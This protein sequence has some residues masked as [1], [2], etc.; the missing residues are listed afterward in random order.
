MYNYAAL[1]TDVNEIIG[2]IASAFPAKEGIEVR[3]ELYNDLNFNNMIRADEASIDERTGTGKLLEILLHTTEGNEYKQFDYINKS[4]GDVTK[5]K[6]FYTI[7]ASINYINR[8]NT[9]YQYASNNANVFN[10]SSQVKINNLSRMNEVFEI[11]KTHKQDFMY[12]YKSGSNTIKNTY[13]ALVFIL[14]DL[15][16][17]NMIDVTNFMEH[18]VQSELR[19]E[20]KVPF[21]VQWSMSRNGRYMRSVDR[22][23]KVFHDGSWNK[24]VMVIRNQNKKYVMEEAASIGLLIAIIGAIPLIAVTILYLIRFFIAFYFETAVD[25]K[26]K[27]GALADYISE[28]AKSE[29]NPAAL[30]KQT[31]A[32][33]ILRNTANFLS[34]KI[35]K[36]DAVGMAKVVEADRELKT[37][38]YIS[39]REYN[40]LTNSGINTAEI[41]FE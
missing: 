11:L 5:L 7:N 31:K 41:T 4:K 30:Y 28:V 35:L 34:T 32:V 6:D 17:M 9:D 3:K 19:D 40:N 36:E 10:I 37:T 18:S 14:V 21:R 39:D 16:C 26:Q 33:R 12:G 20:S 27:C 8:I 15:V 29:D 24:L 1:G 2:D 38:A 23:I 22:L 25:L 13:C